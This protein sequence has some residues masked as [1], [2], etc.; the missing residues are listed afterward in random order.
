MV[1]LTLNA[2][3]KLDA[4]LRPTRDAIA[5]PAKAAMAALVCVMAGA[6]PVML[7]EMAGTALARVCKTLAAAVPLACTI[8]KPWPSD[9]IPAPALAIPP[10]CAVILP[11]PTATAPRDAAISARLVLVIITTPLASSLKPLPAF[12]AAFPIESKIPAIPS[13]IDLTALPNPSITPLA[14]SRI[15]LICSPNVLNRL[16]MLSIIGLI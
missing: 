11:T 3:T 8:T 14:P 16:V 10:L 7:D 13:R 2:V 1:R 4:T 9:F 15:F 6:R 12:K 5:P